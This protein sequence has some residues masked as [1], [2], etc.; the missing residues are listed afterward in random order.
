MRYLTETTYKKKKVPPRGH[1][2]ITG[3]L[4]SRF[5]SVKK[6]SWSIEEF[7]NSAVLKE[8]GEK[9]GDAFVDIKL[10]GGLVDV[11]RA[12]RIQFTPV[13]RAHSQVTFIHDPLRASRGSAF[14]H[15][16]THLVQNV[17]R[18]R[19]RVGAEPIALL[20]YMY[21]KLFPLV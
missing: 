17:P 5:Y 12:D 1:S 4:N 15:L 2:N 13:I 9:L 20:N 10:P 18:F 14:V 6:Y 19:K 7:F 8:P 16:F 11:E 21:Y 3:S